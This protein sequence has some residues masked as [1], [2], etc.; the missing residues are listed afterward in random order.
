MSGTTL[1]YQPRR[2][3]SWIWVTPVSISAFC[4]LISSR[5]SFQTHLILVKAREKVLDMT[6]NR[7]PYLVDHAIEQAAP[8]NEQAQCH[9]DDQEPTRPWCIRTVNDPHEER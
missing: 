9:A 6:T 3:L 2:H 7:L 8:I 5:T 1:R 4:V